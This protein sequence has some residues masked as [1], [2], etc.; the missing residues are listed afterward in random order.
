MQTV[1]IDDDATALFL[2][3]R[4]FQRE[5]IAQQLTSFQSPVKALAYL[6]QQALAGALPQVILLD[7]NMPVLNGWEVL[8]ALKPLESQ[9]LGRC[10]VYIL[11]SSLAPSVTSR[12]QDHLLVAGILPKPLDKYQIQ[13][14]QARTQWRCVPTRDGGTSY[15]THHT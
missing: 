2:T 14:I 10:S 9:L 11:T 15:N 5:G 13:V 8:E 12:V 1:L 6:R 7:L 3:A 4:I